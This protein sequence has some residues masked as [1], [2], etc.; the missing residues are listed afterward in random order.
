MGSFDICPFMVIK[1]SA[2]LCFKKYNVYVVCT[3]IRKALGERCGID[4]WG[5]FHAGPQGTG[6]CP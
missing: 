2:Y 1:L 3:I 6:N 5:S 4:V